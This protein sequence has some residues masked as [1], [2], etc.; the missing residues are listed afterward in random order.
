MMA[1]GAVVLARTP[2]PVAPDEAASDHPPAN[3]PAT[4]G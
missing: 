1:V 2:P 4:T 3:T